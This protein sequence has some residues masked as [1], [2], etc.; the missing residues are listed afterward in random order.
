[1]YLS[2]FAIDLFL[3]GCRIPYVVLFLCFEKSRFEILVLHCKCPAETDR[4][5]AQTKTEEFSI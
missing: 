5:R 3:Y 2:M 1:M 4:D